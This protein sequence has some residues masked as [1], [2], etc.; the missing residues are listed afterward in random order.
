MNGV[1]E[2]I[3]FMEKNF[4]LLEMTIRV[5]GETSHFSETCN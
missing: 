3:S 5:Q 1:E 2:Q 4:A